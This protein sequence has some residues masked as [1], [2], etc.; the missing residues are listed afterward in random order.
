MAKVEWH[1]GELYPRVGFIVTNL[2]RPANRVFNF[3]KQRGTAEQWIKEDKNAIKGTHLSCRS[4]QANAAPVQLHALAYNLANFLRTLALPPELERW[5]LTTIREK[6]IRIGGRVV[7][8]ARDTTFQLARSPS[9]ACCSTASCRRSIIFGDSGPPCVSRISSTQ[10]HEPPSGELRLMLRKTGRK[11]SVARQLATRRRTT[12]PGQVKMTGS[13]FHRTKNGVFFIQEERI[14]RS[15]GEWRFKV[16]MVSYQY[17]FWSLVNQAKQDAA[18]ARKSRSGLFLV[19]G[20][21][22]CALTLADFIPSQ[23]RIHSD[24][25]QASIK[26]LSYLEY[27]LQDFAVVPCMLVT[28]RSILLHETR[29]VFSVWPRLGSFALCLAATQQLPRLFEF[30]LHET[31][32]AAALSALAGIVMIRFVLAFPM[33]AIDRPAPLR[34]SWQDTRRHWWFIFGVLFHVNLPLF[35]LVFVAVLVTWVFFSLV[36]FAGGPAEIALCILLPWFILTLA[37][38]SAAAASWLYRKYT[39]DG[40]TSTGRMSDASD[41]AAIFRI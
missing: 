8:H 34:Q 19:S 27:V 4:M 11:T 3:Y 14:D 16:V 38:R 18:V 35:V 29:G 39:L 31:M 9:P 22:I 2:S 26:L 20:L 30:F 5:S 36:D 28:H 32:L 10:T 7:A 12:I 23:L 6:L 41:A 17:E 21:V 33:I 37:M 13:P 25:L 24:M 1:P 15:S 40:A